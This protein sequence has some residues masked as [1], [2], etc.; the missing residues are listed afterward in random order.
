MKKES[1]YLDSEIWHE[2]TSA[3][4]PK[5]ERRRRKFSCCYAAGATFSISRIVDFRSYTTFV[6]VQDFW[7]N[8]KNPTKS[9]KNRT[10]KYPRKIKR[11]HKIFE[12]DFFKRSSEMKN[13]FQFSVN[14]QL[15]YTLILSLIEHQRKRTLQYSFVQKSYCVAGWLQKLARLVIT[16]IV[17]LPNWLHFST[18]TG[19][20][21]KFWFKY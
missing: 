5:F 19:R 12:F 10:N 13:W 8:V 1:R 2:Q 6:N 3:C 17:D 16:C 4:V 21:S 20:P 7:Y 11:F 15:C 14:F 9:H 18:H